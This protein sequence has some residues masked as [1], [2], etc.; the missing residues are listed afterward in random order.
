[1]AQR[2]FGSPTVQINGIDI[3]GL[4]ALTK[5]SD[6]CC[7]LYNAGGTLRGQPSKELIRT[8]L[9]SERNET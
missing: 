2:F 3:E 1:M 9:S 4:N 7:R 8:A 5:E 6:L